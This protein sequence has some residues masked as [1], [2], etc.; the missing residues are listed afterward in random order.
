[1]H[2]ERAGAT[3]GAHAPRYAHR[4]NDGPVRTHDQ[5]K[6]PEW[7]AAATG[8][9]PDDWYERID[10][11]NGRATGHTAIA[12]WLIEE[13]DGWWAQAVTIGYEQ[14]RGLR[15]P[16]QRSDG[17]FAVTGSKQVPGFPGEVLDAV[18]PV[19]SDRFGMAPTEPRLEARHRPH[20]GGTGTP[21]RSGPH[22]GCEGRA[23]VD[24]RGPLTVNCSALRF[25]RPG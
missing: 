16:G 19:F 9:H 22:G 18:I 8:M 17:T 7:I 10:V 6:A 15:V 1:M 3:H 23:R 13:I 14:S 11:V 4:M 5:T 24:A 25:G 20:R 2:R 21:H 12:A